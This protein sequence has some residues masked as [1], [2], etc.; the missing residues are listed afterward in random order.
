[1][2]PRGR[3]PGT[4]CRSTPAR[5]PAGCM[6]YTDAMT[7]NAEVSPDSCG[8]KH[9]PSPEG[10]SGEWRGA[11]K[12]PQELTGHRRIGQDGEG[13]DTV[14]LVLGRPGKQRSLWGEP[15]PSAEAE[16]QARVTRNWRWAVKEYSR[17]EGQE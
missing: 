1:M 12:Q 3:L 16:T 5:V 2:G 8:S 17:S 4:T 7:K 11:P 6:A 15:P 14:R 10:S 13:A 9:V